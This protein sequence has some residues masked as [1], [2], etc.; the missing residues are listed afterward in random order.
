MDQTGPPVSKERVAILGGGVA[1]LAA[2]WRLSEPGWQKRFQSITVYERSWRLGGKAASSRGPNGRIEEHGLH[3]WLGYYE[4]AFRLVR[5]VY[6]ELDRESRRPEAPFKKWTDAFKP[7]SEIGLEDFRDGRWDHWVATFSPNDEIPGEPDAGSGP[8]SVLDF[9]RRSLRLLADFYGSLEDQAAPSGKVTISAS[10]TP[11]PASPWGIDGAMGKKLMASVLAAAMQGVSVIRSEQQILTG[12]IPGLEPLGE[13]LN[14]LHRRLRGMV[15]KDNAARQLWALADLMFTTVRGILADG[16]LTHPKGFSAINDEEYRDWM[17]RHGASPETLDSPLVRGVY[18]LVFGFQDG[19]PARPRFAAGLGLFLSGKLF[20]E[21]RGAICWKL[22]GGMGDVLMAP[23]YEALAERGVRF[24]FF[25]RVEALRLSTE[26]DSIAA[27]EISRQVTLPAG[28]DSYQP[29]V[30]VGGLPCF[31]S[32]PALAQAADPRTDY[33]S[34]WSSA[35]EGSMTVL[36]NGKDFDRIVLAI[37]VGMIPYICSDLVESNP[38]WRSM[39][40]HLGTVATQ[41]FQLW[42]SADSS[43]LGWDRPGVTMT[44]FLKPFETWSS[45]DQL[46]AV[47]QWPPDARPRTVTYFCNTLPT[48]GSP[49]RNDRDFPKR[50]HERVREN[51]VAVLREG[52]RYFWPGAVDE[53]EITF[54]WDLLVGGGERSGEDRFDSQFWRANVDPSERY[55][56]SLP[57]SDKYRL[58]TD[59]SGYENLVLAGDWIDCGLNAGC[60]EAAVMSGFQA[61]NAL[62]GNPITDRIAG[63]YMDWG[64]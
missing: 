64:K 34:I 40:D 60:L 61:A 7:A 19:D 14:Q 33:E 13:A 57:G 42:L 8:M 54:R 9:V 58:R 5:E 15:M 10:P 63:Y 38:R 50:E 27:V 52:V 11:P 32:Q 21:Y 39:V 1:G 36:E 62:V 12:S 37:P 47:E 43:E 25:S 51:A 4:N 30:D 59:A 20:F 17:E 23:L 41:A 29:L 3:V 18:D 28:P 49:D 55:V 35:G 48:V 44:G 24:E 53:K 56:L 22:S 45:M 6:E 16:L 2:A 46:L 26:G 31:P